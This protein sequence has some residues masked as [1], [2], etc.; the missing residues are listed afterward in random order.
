MRDKTLKWASLPPHATSLPMTLNIFKTTQKCL[1]FADIST[2]NKNKGI[3]WSAL[4]DFHYLLLKEIYNFFN[5][6]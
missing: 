6:D 4:L 2:K 5:K 1:V 3:V